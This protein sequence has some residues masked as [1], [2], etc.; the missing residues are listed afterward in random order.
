MQLNDHG[1]PLAQGG[2]LG[3]QSTDSASRSVFF[4]A[5]CNPSQDSCLPTAAHHEQER[6]CSWRGVEQ[7]EVEENPTL[8]L[9]KQTCWTL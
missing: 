9:I 8:D 5:V 4:S 2:L 7:A 6:V 3:F 1:A